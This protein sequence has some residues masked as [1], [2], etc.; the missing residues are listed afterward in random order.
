MEPKFVFRIAIVPRLV[1]FAA[2]FRPALYPLALGAAVSKVMSV[3][4]C[5]S[6]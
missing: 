6:F 3:S 1:F 5:G 4:S 2:H